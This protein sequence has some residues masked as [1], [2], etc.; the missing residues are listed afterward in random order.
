MWRVAAACTGGVS[1]IALRERPLGLTP[2]S[3]RAIISLLVRVHLGGFLMNNASYAAASLSLAE[4]QARFRALDALV[5]TDMDEATYV[6]WARD[7][8]A[9]WQ[10][11]LTLSEILRNNA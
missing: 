8:E 7:H 2:L 1:D 5:Y 9:A 3:R 11:I 6:S 4:A 10:E